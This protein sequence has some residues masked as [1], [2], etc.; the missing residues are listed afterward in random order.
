MAADRQRINKRLVD[1][2]SA[3]GTDRLFWDSEL[4]GFGLRISPP[5]RLTYILQYR[6]DGRQRRFKIGTHGSPWAPEGAR[7]EAKPLLGRIAEGEGPQQAKFDERVE[8][9]VAQLCDLYLAEG[10]LTR[11]E[12]SIA[13]ARSDISDCW[14][15]CARMA[16]GPSLNQRTRFTVTLYDK[17]CEQD[18]H[19]HG[20]KRFLTLTEKEG[21]REAIIE[22]LGD[23]DSLCIGRSADPGSWIEVRLADFNAPGLHAASGARAKSA[24]ENVALGRPASCTAVQGRGA[25]TGL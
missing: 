12:T 16:S 23:G 5:G 1:S 8:M 6:L 18:G 25:G 22:H 11:K 15:L 7:Q 17:W 9:L 2:L 19:Q 14:R 21:G 10:L 4:L 20:L 3:D 13:S 24:L